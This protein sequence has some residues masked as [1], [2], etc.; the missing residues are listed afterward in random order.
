MKKNGG[1]LG[2]PLALGGADALAHALPAA[3]AL[4]L[5]VAD[6]LADAKPLA[7]QAAL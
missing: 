3:L 2:E 1:A 6:A 4:A 5:G 7:E